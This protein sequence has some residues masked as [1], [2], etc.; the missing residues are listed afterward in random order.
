MPREFDRKAHSAQ[1]DSHIVHFDL[2]KGEM[3]YEPCPDIDDTYILNEILLKC[4]YEA[5]QN[6]DYLTDYG[7]GM[8]TFAKDILSLVDYLT[9]MKAGFRAPIPHTY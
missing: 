9:E 8:Q 3:V 4:E 1:S 2:E 7:A 6:P 5:G